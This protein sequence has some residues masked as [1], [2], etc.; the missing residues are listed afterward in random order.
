[1][2]IKILKRVS[3]CYV[4]TCKSC[5]TKFKYDDED[6]EEVAFGYGDPDYEEVVKCPVCGKYI[7]HSEKNKHYGKIKKEPD[8][9]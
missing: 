2:S 8:D 5:R 9:N 7:D 4:V 1:M 6:V 3:H